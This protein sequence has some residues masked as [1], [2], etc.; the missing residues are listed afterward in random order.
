M[1]ITIRSASNLWDR[2]SWL[3]RIIDGK[4]PGDILEVETRWEKSV[5][6]SLMESFQ[7]EQMGYYKSLDTYAF[8]ET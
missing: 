2:F 3:E 7:S 6:V 8:L 5:I 4:I 1:L